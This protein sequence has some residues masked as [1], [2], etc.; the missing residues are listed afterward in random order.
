VIDRGVKWQVALLAFLITLAVSC[1]SVTFLARVRA[2]WRE[3]AMAERAT[4]T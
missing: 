3:A 1:A 2:G 4:E